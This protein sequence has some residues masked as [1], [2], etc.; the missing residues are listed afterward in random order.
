MRVIVTGGTGMIGRALVKSMTA[1]GYQV[2]IL[3]RNPRQS[4]PMPETINFYEWDAATPD[5]W[6]HIVD[7]ADAIVNLA[8]ANIAGE[9]FLPAKWTRERKKAILESRIKAGEA[10][11]AAVQ[12]ATI[13]PKVVIQ[14][15][16]VGYYGT[17]SADVTITEQS[18]AGDDYLA[19]VCQQWEASTAPVEAE[20]VRRAII[21]TGV[22][23]DQDE[24]SLP[25]LAL[26]FKLFAGGPL[27]SGKQPFPWIHIDDEVN[28]IRF[29]IDNGEASG[30]FNLT[31][32]QPL[33]N[34]EFARVLGRVLR[35]PAFFPTPGFAFRTAFGEVATIILEGQKALPTRLQELGFN[36]KYETAE[37]ALTAI[38]RPAELA[39]TA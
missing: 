27:G 30:P 39:T 3:S 28:A 33:T 12:A 26:P 16:A 7:G 38:Y 8:G 29:L 23:L 5:G 34:A 31:G 11:S 1:D 10:V 37:A 24:G 35:R 9:S 36:F 4:G 13:K 22:V 20:D 6:G 14:A 25:R 2:D 18:P 15:S 19:D 17:H 32:P 21:R